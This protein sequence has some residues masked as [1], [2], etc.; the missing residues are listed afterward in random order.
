MYDPQ[1]ISTVLTKQQEETA[2]KIAERI[3]DSWAAE[4]LSQGWTH[5]HTRNDLSKEHPCLVPY[6]RLTHDEK[7]FDIV[8]ARTV[9]SVLGDLKAENDCIAMIWRWS[10]FL[11]IVA[12]LTSLGR[13]VGE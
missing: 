8:T 7:Q 12:Y 1:P 9:I 2:V 13:T 6:H 4:R 5:G 10:I 3:H 11:V